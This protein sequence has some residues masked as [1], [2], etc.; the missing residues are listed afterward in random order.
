MCTSLR[1]DFCGTGMGRHRTELLQ[2]LDHVLGQLD[3]G[4]DHLKQQN[5]RLDGQDL[6]LMKRRYG[7]LREVLLEVD[8]RTFFPITMNSRMLILRWKYRRYRATSTTLL[9]LTHSSAHGTVC[10]VAPT[11]LIYTAFGVSQAFS[12]K[13]LFFS[14][15]TPCAIVLPSL[16]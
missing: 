13:L 2:R 5:P 14:C 8:R 15:W 9:S 1:E 3:R 7:K 6:F 11:R 12:V 16:R 4:L 10:L